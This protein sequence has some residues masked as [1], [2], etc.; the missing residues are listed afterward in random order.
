MIC[1][2]N[3]IEVGQELITTHHKDP[4]TVLEVHE[5]KDSFSARD[6]EGNIWKNLSSYDVTRIKKS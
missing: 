3:E 1:T 4:M 5:T 6:H 2:I